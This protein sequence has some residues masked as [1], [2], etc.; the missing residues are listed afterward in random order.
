MHLKIFVCSGLRLAD[1]T[2][3]L[4]HSPPQLGENISLPQGRENIMKGL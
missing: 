3:P 1:P 2:K 4:Y